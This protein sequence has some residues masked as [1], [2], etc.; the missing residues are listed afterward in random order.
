SRAMAAPMRRAAPVTSTTGA[1]ATLAGMGGSYKVWRHTHAMTLRMDK[2]YA[3]LDRPWMHTVLGCVA[4]VVRA[5]RCAWLT[6][7]VLKRVMRFA[8]RRTRWSWD[9]AMFNR[10]VFLRL[11]QVVPMLII[12]HGLTAVPGVP[13]NVEAVV[14]AVAAVMI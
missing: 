8:T 2:L 4:L 11:A 1:E 12:Y 14:R 9:D 13:A 10:G 3:L 7:D 6:R 5:W